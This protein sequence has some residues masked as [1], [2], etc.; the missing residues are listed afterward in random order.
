MDATYCDHNL[1]LFQY[2]IMI[3]S[4]FSAT[5]WVDIWKKMGKTSIFCTKTYKKV[6]YKKGKKP[7]RINKKPEFLWS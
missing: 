5:T 7:H 6:T 3:P 4:L 2:E 1:F